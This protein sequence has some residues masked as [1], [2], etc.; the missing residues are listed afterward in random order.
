MAISKLFAEL[1]TDG[2]L[3]N[4]LRPRQNGCHFANNIFKYIFLSE[5]VSI[6]IN[7]SLKCVPMGQIDNIPELV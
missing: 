4:T 7:I 5:N 1:Q 3:L 6:S 2:N